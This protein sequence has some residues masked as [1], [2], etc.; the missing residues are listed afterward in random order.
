M[1][2]QKILITDTAPLYPPLWGGPKRIWNL[3]SHFPGD[4]FDITYVGVNFSL[5]KKKRYFFQRINDNFSQVLCSFPNHYYLWHAFERRFFRNTSLDLFVYLLMHT[6]WHFRYALF[7][8]N[9]DIITCSHP[10]SSLSINKDNSK[11]FI[12][13]AHNCEYLLMEQILK[14]HPLRKLVL[15]KVKKI[16]EDACVKSDL[17]LV[18]SDKEKQDFIDLYKISPKKIS[19]IPNGTEITERPKREQKISARISLSLSENEKIAIFI[20]TFYKPN[21]DAVSFIIDE[22]AEKLKNIRFLIV[23]SVFDFFRA[24]T[25]PDN[26]AFLGRVSEENLANALLSADIAINPMF[27]GSGVNIKMLDY[28]A[29]SL[30]II[31]TEC[32][33]RGI[34]KKQGRDAFLVSAKQDFAQNIEKLLKNDSLMNSLSLNSEELAREKY[35]WRKISSDL[36]ELII[37]RVNRI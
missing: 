35:D 31:S 24:K 32:G 27:E 3:Y 23:G 11:F 7:S 14:K 13:D 37:N 9:A 36:R 12:Y 30:P 15:R 18:C 6:D 5:E 17:I 29:Y 4:Y 33:S 34:E 20:G 8:Q 10:W 2:K 21:I 16:E 22:L 26:I 1:K 19:I 28:M 25:L